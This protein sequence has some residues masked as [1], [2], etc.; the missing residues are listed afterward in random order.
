M[1]DIVNSMLPCPCTQY[2]AFQ[3]PVST[4]GD[5]CSAYTFLQI[6]TGERVSY[7]NRFRVAALN[8]GQKMAIN[9]S[10]QYQAGTHFS[11]RGHHQQPAS[12]P[13][14]ERESYSGGTW[15]ACQPGPGQTSRGL[16]GRLR[17]LSTGLIPHA[18]LY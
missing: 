16:I 11:I 15:E 4:T 14:R 6:S 9:M 17:H 12:I 8:I 18:S 13:P 10:H 2:D 5:G 1:Y 7:M 3:S